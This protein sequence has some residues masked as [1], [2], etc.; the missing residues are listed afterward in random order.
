MAREIVARNQPADVSGVDTPKVHMN[1]IF[2]EMKTQL[3][4][5]YE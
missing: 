1:V 3:Y 5:T 2:D 4:E